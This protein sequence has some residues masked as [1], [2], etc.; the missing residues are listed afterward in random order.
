MPMVGPFPCEDAAGRWGLG[1]PCELPPYSILPAP[2]WGTLLIPG[3]LL[4][5]VHPQM[6]WVV[7]DLPQGA[8]SHKGSSW[9]PLT[10]AGGW[11][12]SCGL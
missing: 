6:E 7:G 8:A 1:V 10:A 4:P 12:G 9:Q 11:D 2:Q 5:Y 3:Y